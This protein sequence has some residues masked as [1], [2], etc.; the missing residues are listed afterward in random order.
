MNRHLR[1]RG[2]TATP[3][4]RDDAGIALVASMALVAIVG[5][6]MLTMLA[7]SLRES[8]QSGRDR[9][10]SSAVST[11]E[12]LVDQ[13][14]AQVQSV[15]P[16][17]LPCGVGAPVV[18][19]QAAPDTL[20]I[21][22]TVTYY[23]A[24]GTAITCANLASSVATQA[25]VT[26]TSVSGA[27]AGQAPA[28]RTVESLIKL[29]PTFAYGLDKAIFGSSGVVLAN[30]GEIFGEPGKTNADIYTNG[31][32]SC[33]NNQRYHG[34]VF[35]QGQITL[36]NSCVIDVDAWS[37]TGFTGTS[38]S[39]TI[40]GDVRVSNGNAEAI[41][42]MSIGGRVFAATVSGTYCSTYP[43]KCST[44]AG[45]TAAPP[46]QAFPQLP[47]NTATQA[48][49]A[50]APASQG[51][52][53][54]NVVTI[55]TCTP[56]GSTNGPGQWIMDNAATLTQPTILR[57]TCQ[58]VID[59]NNNNINLADNLAIFADGGIAFRNSLTIDSTTS[60]VR[61][62]YLIQPWGATCAT[63]GITLDN[64]VTITS[65]V[66]ELIYTPCN[67]VKA[68]NTDHYGQI[69]AGG[70]A[71]VDNALT[72]YYRPLPVW[73]QTGTTSTVASYALDILY[74]RENR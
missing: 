26:A 32:F 2:G 11:A 34:S 46:V 35:A 54:T 71:T 45:V 74:K 51:G 53:Y 55:N 66:N 31:S 24:T 20:T 22:R 29:N 49:W 15:A 17:S 64:R 4:P 39:V 68:N 5:T 33:D 23:D 47:W 10:R 28:R 37:A 38:P 16:A 56:I 69:Y 48:A 67:V 1:R 19:T 7:Y 14:L 50:A 18:S 70:T 6:L 13:T 27:I 43:A 40:S 8:R 61:N 3:L 62:L 36:S 73:G 9:Q 21:T 44:G 52:P 60:A 12:G 59:R 57:T 72:M 42:Q 65:R 30:R 25:L 63:D 58:V 41:S